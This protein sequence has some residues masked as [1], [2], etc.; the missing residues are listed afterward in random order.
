MPSISVKNQQC[1]S[2]SYHQ[3][4]CPSMLYSC[5]FCKMITVDSKL[6][7]DYCCFYTIFSSTCLPQ[8]CDKGKSW[9]MQLWIH[10]KP[11]CVLQSQ[12]QERRKIQTWNQVFQFETISYHC[13]TTHTC[14]RWEDMHVGDNTSSVN[15]CG[16]QSSLSLCTPVC[17]SYRKLVRTLHGE[18]I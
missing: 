6:H 3:N 9:L 7:K 8:I 15:N 1:R 12:V 18:Y 11:T 4:I 17:Y 13:Q 5:K 16:W 14:K 10:V 2:E